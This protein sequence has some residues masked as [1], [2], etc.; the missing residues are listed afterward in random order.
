MKVLVI[1][2]GGRCHA[3]AWKLF[4]S[5][6]N[7]EVYVAPGNAGM[8]FAKCVNIDELDNEG[9]VKFAIE[10]KIDLTV[11]GPEAALSN[12]IVNVFKENGLRIFGPSKEAAIIEA[13]KEFTKDLMKKYNVPTAKYEAFDNY[14]DAYNYLVK[15]GAPIVIKYDGLAAGKGVVVANTFDEANDALVTMLKDKKYGNA[16]VVIE[17]CLVGP[18]FSLMAFVN[19]EKVFPMML[20]QDHKRAFEDRKS[21][22]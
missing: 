6:H 9:L 21:V 19:G 7:P 15:E 12:G 3:I 20:S 17:E 13:S 10:N 22:V 11:V 18:E 1:G 2:R 16:R 4:N 14:E 5:K 8:T